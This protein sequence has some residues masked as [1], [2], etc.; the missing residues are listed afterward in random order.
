M[1]SVI[2][3]AQQTAKQGA[4]LGITLGAAGVYGDAVVFTDR[5]SVPALDRSARLVAGVLALVGPDAE[6]IGWALVTIVERGRGTL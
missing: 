2:G 1:G 6:G 5:R 4:A 3:R